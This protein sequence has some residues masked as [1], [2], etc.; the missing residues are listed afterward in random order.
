MKK[1]R[2]IFILGSI[3]LLAVGGVILSHHVLFPNAKENTRVYLQCMQTPQGV[4]L[5]QL[6]NMFGPVHIGHD[7][8]PLHEYW[9]GSHEYSVA[10]SAYIVA[11]VNKSTG[12]VVRLSC[13]EGSL[14]WEVSA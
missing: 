13:G 2:V 5:D 14:A 10:H 4:T 1:R 8:G 12:Q 7:D 9:F 3:A 11:E 6:K